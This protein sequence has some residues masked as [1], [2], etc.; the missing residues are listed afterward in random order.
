MGDSSLLARLRPAD[1]HRDRSGA[2]CSTTQLQHA[3]ALRLGASALGSEPPDAA[4]LAVGLVGGVRLPMHDLLLDRSYHGR[5]LQRSSDHLH[6]HLAPL[7][8]GLRVGVVGVGGA[9]WQASLLAGV[10]LAGHSGVRR[11]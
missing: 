10:A 3:A 1:S 8:C 7:L 11:P 2:D 4:P 6:Q 9:L 5:V